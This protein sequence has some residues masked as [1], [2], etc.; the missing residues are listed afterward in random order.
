MPSKAL[1]VIYQ[2]W[3]G[4]D[5]KPVKTL[6]GHEAKVT[7]SDISAGNFGNLNKLSLN[8]SFFSPLS[9]CIYS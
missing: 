6:P 2:V 7:A 3:S 8:L 4:R 1:N 9:F 5:F